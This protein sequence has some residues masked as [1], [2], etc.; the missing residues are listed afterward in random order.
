MAYAASVADRREGGSLIEPGRRIVVVPYHPGRLRDLSAQKSGDEVDAV[1]DEL[2]G[3]T[4][5]ERPGLFDLILIASGIGLVGWALLTNSPGLALPVGV[6][7]LVLG[8][9]LPARSLIRTGRARRRA[10]AQRRALRDGYPLDIGH[11]E[12]AALARAHARLMET[13]DND[14][15]RVE[16]QALEAGHLALVEVATLL[17]GRPPLV[18]AEL[19]YVTERTQAIRDTTSQLVRTQRA[20]SRAAAAG[21]EE[22]FEARARRAEALTQARQELS[23]AHGLGSVGQLEAVRGLLRQERSSG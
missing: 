14:P 18:A 17:A 22:A 2:F 3:E 23:D 20:R 12:T 13:V 4:T 10:R 6:I 16:T 7:A 9:A 1:I 21:D 11:G 5:A 19:S 15:G 8:L